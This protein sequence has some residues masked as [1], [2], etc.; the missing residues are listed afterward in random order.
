M[1]YQSKIKIIGLQGAHLC[2]HHHQEYVQVPK[3]AS[4]L[5]EEDIR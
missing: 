2:F 4:P 5:E 1:Q 3:V